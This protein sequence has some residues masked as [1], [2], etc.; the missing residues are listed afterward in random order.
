MN[1]L[2]LAINYCRKHFYLLFLG[3]ALPAIAIDLLTSF[4]FINLG[5]DGNSSESIFTERLQEVAIPAAIVLLITVIVSTTFSGAIILAFQA[6]DKGNTINVL[7][8]Y[9]IAFRRFISLLGVALIQ[10]FIFGFGLL[11]LVL[12]G[13]YFLGRLG[14][15]T[16]YVMLRGQKT[17]EALGNAW[18][19]SDVH[20]PRL[21]LLCLFFLGTQLMFGL[22]GGLIIQEE[23]PFFIVLTALVKYLTT[24]PLTYLFYS[25]YRSL[26]S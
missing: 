21:F 13:F 11:L 6:V 10:S 18:E 15:S 22:I 23:N 26:N 16:S 20:G 1:Q 7:S 8:L 14:M 25:L 3:I 24:I 4:Y 2:I 12:P 9:L 19:S 5:L 17:F